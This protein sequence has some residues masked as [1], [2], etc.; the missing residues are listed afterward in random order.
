MSTIEEFFSK[1][2]NN[3]LFE[4]FI[5]FLKSKLQNDQTLSESDLLDSYSEFNKKYNTSMKT[6][7]ESF[8]RNVYSSFSELPDID[9]SEKNKF[10]ESFFRQLEL[11]KVHTIVNNNE[12]KNQEIDLDFLYS[13]LKDKKTSTDIQDDNSLDR[14]LQQT[15]IHAEFLST[16]LSILNSKS[17]TIAILDF[18]Q[19]TIDPILYS[20]VLSKDISIG[21]IDDIKDYIEKDLNFQ[22]SI[23]IINNQ[24]IQS[25]LQKMVSF[26]NL[27]MVSILEKSDTIQT[28]KGTMEYLL[29]QGKILETVILFYLLW[30]SLYYSLITKTIQNRLI[31]L[32]NLS[33]RDNLDTEQKKDL[34]KELRILYSLLQ[35]L[36]DFYKSIDLNTGSLKNVHFVHDN[37]PYYWPSDSFYKEIL[38]FV[39]HCIT[40]TPIPIRTK[41]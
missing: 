33:Q 19:N 22:T 16:S 2:N 25:L 39:N 13:I 23:N 8:F 1:T 30:I 40:K 24:Q 15:G 37:N 28:V 6:L 35:T 31:N 17:D 38:D 14:L 10:I 4:Q 12:L 26:S 21:S 11:S 18:I 5:N 29:I 41:H 36:T 34:I 27:N 20:Y 3:P 32:E 7:G 9:Q